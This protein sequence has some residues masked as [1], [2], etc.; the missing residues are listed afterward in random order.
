MTNRSQH[1]Y[2][3]ETDRTINFLTAR[4]VIGP[5]QV[6]ITTRY[7]ITYMQQWKWHPPKQWFYNGHYSLRLAMS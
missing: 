6:A 4:H 5:V 7:R 2:D 1:L 3:R